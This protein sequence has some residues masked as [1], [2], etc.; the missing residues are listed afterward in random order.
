LASGAPAGSQPLAELLSVGA[1]RERPI[2]PKESHAYR[3]EVAGTPLLVTVEQ[4]SV[5]LVL[6]IRGPAGATLGTDAGESRWGT[7]VVLLEGAGE[8]RIEVR[9]KASSGWPGSY[10]LRV[11]AIEED[12]EGAGGV[13][14]GPAGPAGARRA[15]WV[16]LSRGGAEIFAADAPEARTRAIETHRA[17]LAAWSALGERRQEAEC[18]AR[19]AALERAASDRKPAAED[20]E[21]A[22]TLWH[23]LG[24]PE[25]EAAARNELG[26]VRRELGSYDGSR[27]ALESA[28]TLWKGLGRRFDGAESQG[29]LCLLEQTVGN[30]SAARA[31]YQEPLAL[32]RE[33]GDRSGEGQILNNLGGIEDLLGNPDAALEHYGQALALRRAVG[34]PLGEAQTLNNLG[35]LRRTLGDWQEALRLFAEGREILR[36]KEDRALQAALLGNLGYTYLSLGEV[37]RALPFLEEALRLRRE[38]PDPRGEVVTLNN[39]G[40][41]RR[42]LGETKAALALHSEAR[43]KAEALGDL[44]QEAVSR[45]R[46]TEVEIELGE[47]PAA[48]GTLAPALAALRQAGQRLGE[49]QALHLKGR[50]FLRGGRP[51]E[52]LPVLREALAGRR[53]LRDR[54][55][56]ADELQSLAEAERAVGEAEAARAHAEEAVARV[57]ELRAGI[58]SLDLRAAFLATQR[59]AYGTSI[60]LLMDRHRADPGGAWDRQA[61]AV[62]ERARA[63][64]LLDAL[65]A[66]GGGSGVAKVPAQL[67]DQ[68]RA[69][70]HRLSSRAES[71]LRQQS[72]A[73]AEALGKEVET[74]LA[75]LDRVEAEIRRA[76]PQD[77]ALGLQAAAGLP[78]I[79]DLLEPG[80]VLLELALGEE[81]S[82]LWLVEGTE[83]RSVVLPPQRE[84]EALARRVFADLSTVEAGGGGREAAARLGR[85]LLGPVWERAA[86]A[87]RWVIVPD[88]ALHSLPFAALPAPDGTGRLLLEKVEID[89]LPSATT[90]AQQRRR[91]PPA[92]SRRAAILADPV[93][94][95]SD[96][97]VAPPS[98]QARAVP[99][100]EAA[101]GGPMRGAEEAPPFE[102]LPA[103]GRE[104]EE[105]AGLAP[106]GE[107]WIARGFAA[108]R[109]AVLAGALRDFRVVHFATHAVA[110]TRTPELSGLVLSQVDEA[111][112]PR[113]GFLGLSDVYDLRL[114][115]GLVVLSGCRTALGKEVR[116]EGIMGLTRGFLHA[117]VPRVVA[118]LWPVQ[119]RA[120][121]ELMTR[122]YRALWKEG[123]TPAAALRQAQIALRRDPHNPR[124]RDP[125]YW[126]GYVLQGDWR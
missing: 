116:G 101:N 37:Q 117:G 108:S 76:D 78:E 3:L 4:Q 50:A 44:R 22:A 92:S 91:P 20:F 88:G 81:R 52:A 14:A 32:Y 5:D 48:L 80:T 79:A 36:R 12:G 43:R 74:L 122:F 105:I 89:Y 26:L 46:L 8:R 72:G 99:A 68:R 106:P 90:L 118:S 111:G 94:S 59:R 16:L 65:G 21:R 24:E 109:E 19:L 126:A 11:A 100:A 123:R 56:E 121:T 23:E 97:R 69:L 33:V 6:E 9:A 64:S 54:A 15:A 107:V 40:I 95:A 7:E 1:E 104:A 93:F 113:D 124:Y 28:L 38:I 85:L 82:Y 84:I 125:F 61:L 17:A 110:D 53:A 75:E 86:R 66:S 96:P 35:V 70:R 34:D 45:L 63:R 27:A 30:L 83:V 18:L 41:A 112:R 120:A 73:K 71:Q 51:G 119:D 115:A 55:G 49:L 57:E 29:N 62:S 98:R 58:A 10:S 47:V 103:S 13:A 114:D 31:C 87:S 67:L 60:D 42:R 39:L 77:A 25:R 2:A 102:R